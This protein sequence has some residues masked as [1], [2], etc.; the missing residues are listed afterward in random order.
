MK[1]SNINVKQIFKDSCI[2]SKSQF[3][4]K[5]MKMPMVDKIRDQCNKA[6][7]RNEFRREVGNFKTGY[8]DM[9]RSIPTP[10]VHREFGRSPINESNMM[11]DTHG[12]IGK[13]F[14]DSKMSTSSI[15]RNRLDPPV[16][17]RMDY[18]FS[19][20][21]KKKKKVVDLNMEDEMV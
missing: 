19:L 11:S 4:R 17:G 1:Q 14:H 16:V 12:S 10:S 13:I 15:K 5:S 8:K 2:G 18:D 6:F 3:G 7:G 20:D 9:M 21:F